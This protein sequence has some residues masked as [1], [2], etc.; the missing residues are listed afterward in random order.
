MKLYSFHYVTVQCR[1]G[2][3][4]YQV[5]RDS[6]GTFCSFSQSRNPTIIFTLG[7]IVLNFWRLHSHGRLCGGTYS[8]WTIFLLGTHWDFSKDN[9]AVTFPSH[10]PMSWL[11]L[12]PPLAVLCTWGGRRGRGGC[13][14][15]RRPRYRRGAGR[16]GR[17]SR[18]EL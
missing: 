18:L 4:E 16:A 8:T 15:R 11:S 10:Q 5:I 14:G 6:F 9:R 1:G 7:G 17:G 12:C 13:R 3:Y 2:Q